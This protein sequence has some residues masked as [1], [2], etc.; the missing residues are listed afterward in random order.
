MRKDK[1]GDYEHGY[2]IHYQEFSLGMVSYAGKHPLLSPLNDLTAIYI[3]VS[4]YLIIELNFLSEE[5]PRI[6]QQHSSLSYSSLT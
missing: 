6:G 2:I 5:G 4:V 1:N 3:S